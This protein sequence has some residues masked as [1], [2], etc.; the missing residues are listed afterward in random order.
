MNHVFLIGRLAAEPES[1]TT[2]SGI[3]Q[4]SFRLA[5]PRAYKNAQGEREA[6]SHRRRNMWEPVVTRE[7]YARMQN[8]E[9]I[10]KKRNVA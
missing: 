10:L 8:G 4:C 9:R 6:E 1:R 2:Q 3:A 7:D 5:V